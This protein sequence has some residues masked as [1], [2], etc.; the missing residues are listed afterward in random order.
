MSLS[1][2]GERKNPKKV[3]QDFSQVLKWQKHCRTVVTTTHEISGLILLF[4]KSISRKSLLPYRSLISLS[5][6]KG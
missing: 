3:T 4:L 6:T 2:Q 1:P 5:T